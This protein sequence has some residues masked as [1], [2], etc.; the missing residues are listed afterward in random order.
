MR[1]STFIGLFIIT[2][3]FFIFFQIHKHNQIIKLSYQKQKYENK[4]KE[5]LQKKEHLSQKW[6]QM[7]KRSTIKKFAKKN[8]KMSKVKLKQI[9]KL[10]T[11]N[12]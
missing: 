11:I 8:L 12:E 9:K 1:K 5:L 2:H 7:Q 4:K 3:L 6:Y 10:A